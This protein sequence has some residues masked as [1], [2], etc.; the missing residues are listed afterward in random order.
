M[1]VTRHCNGDAVSER[2]RRATGIA[3]YLTLWHTD[4]VSD[5]TNMDGDCQKR[6]DAYEDL[7]NG[8][9]DAATQ[10]YEYGW[11]VIVHRSPSGKR[12]LKC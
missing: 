9:Y 10:L 6:A 12:A 8:Y 11:S 5:S 4:T 2:D 3:K 1:S 7:T